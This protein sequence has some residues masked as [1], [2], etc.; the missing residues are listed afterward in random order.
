[1]PNIFLFGPVGAGK[2]TI[3]ATACLSFFESKGVAPLFNIDSTEGSRLLFEWVE[4]LRKGQ[5][6]QKTLEDTFLRVDAGFESLREHARLGLSFYEASGE[7]LAKLSPLDPDH[8]E[9]EATLFEWLRTTDIALL[10]APTDM[11]EVARSQLLQMLGLLEKRGVVVPT[12]LVFS[13]WD[14]VA[15]K[16]KSALKFGNDKYPE[17][18]KVLARR[19]FRDH[20]KL[21]TFSVGQVET[22]DEHNVISEV[23][24][25]A[26]SKE[27]M[28]WILD[29]VKKQ[30]AVEEA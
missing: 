7:S 18:L 26:G 8:E 15:G 3:C 14:L 23:V 5:F 28:G 17:V 4:R 22:R 11:V 12:A 20:S 21:L 13:K 9:C 1:M 24:F 16:Y 30:G 27:L 10:V 6:P 25:E 19:R 29:E 2:S